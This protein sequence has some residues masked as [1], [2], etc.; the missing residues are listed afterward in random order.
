MLDHFTLAVALVALDLHLLE[1]S[2][3]KLL[4]LYFCATA[5]ARVTCLYVS[6]FATR[7]LARRAYSLF[8]YLKFCRAPIVEVAQGNGHPELHVW[9]LAL[10]AAMPKVSATAE[11]AAKEV[12]GVV[13]LAWGSTLLVLLYA[14][15]AILVVDTARFFV[16]EDLVGF[17]D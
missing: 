5:T 2:W 11:E 6:V 10:P 12:E 16:D 3:R 1:Q 14:F 8:L 7:A 17:G 15:V 13:M 4:S 9:S